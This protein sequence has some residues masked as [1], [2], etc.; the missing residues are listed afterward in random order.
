LGELSNRAV[1][2]ETGNGW[3]RGGDRIY[4]TA[5]WMFVALTLELYSLR[6]L[7]IHFNLLGHSQYLISH[8][9]HHEEYC[10]EADRLSRFDNRG[11]ARQRTAVGNV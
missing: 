11:Q 1:P 6:I 9:L 5:L 7:N 3:L 8:S 2:K 4:C 10:P